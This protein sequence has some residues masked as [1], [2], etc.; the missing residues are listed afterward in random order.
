MRRN[1]ANRP[2]L[3]NLDNQIASQRVGK[4]YNLTGTDHHGR[5]RPGQP[6]HLTAHKMEADVVGFGNYD[7]ETATMLPDFELMYLPRRQGLSV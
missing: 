1:A 4:T 5:I 7:P 3:D 2:R 6:N